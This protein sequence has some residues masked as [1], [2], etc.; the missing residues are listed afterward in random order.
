V[1]TLILVMTRPEIAIQMVLSGFWFTDRGHVVETRCIVSLPILLGRRPNDQFRFN[2]NG[3]RRYAYFFILVFLE[4]KV[5][6]G[7]THIDT[8]LIDSSDRWRG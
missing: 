3:F 5:S 6:N 1:L 8:K 2:T 7:F 4:V